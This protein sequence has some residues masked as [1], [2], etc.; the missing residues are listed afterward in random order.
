MPKAQEDGIRN[1]VF[2]GA[3][4]DHTVMDLDKSFSD[5]DHSDCNNMMNLQLFSEP[6]AS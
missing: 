6:D 4:I 1:N 2:S 5:I 3:C